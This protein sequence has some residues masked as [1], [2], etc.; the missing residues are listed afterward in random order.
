M[1]VKPKYLSYLKYD[2]NTEYDKSG[3]IIKRKRKVK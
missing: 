3:K 2:P 1:T